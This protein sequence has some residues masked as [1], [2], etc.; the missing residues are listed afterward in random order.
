MSATLSPPPLLCRSGGGGGEA[1]GGGGFRASAAECA[2]APSTLLRRVPLPRSS[3]A[4]EDKSD[5]AIAGYAS[6]FWAPDGGRDVVAAGA[7]ADSLAVRPGVAMLHGHDPAR[8]VGVWD[9]LREDGRGLHVRGRI[10]GDTAAGRLCQALARAG[11]LDGLSIGFRARRA[12][13]DRAR[14]LRVLS[15]VDLVEVSLTPNPL[16]TG[17][18]FAPVGSPQP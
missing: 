7:F 3:G 6:L 2:S 18:R 10:S 12:R 8:P 4:G 17:A 15:E 16:L 9:E 14:S 13:S 1:D 11:R 5:L